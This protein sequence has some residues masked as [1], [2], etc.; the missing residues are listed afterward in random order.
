[1]QDDPLRSSRTKMR[2]ERATAATLFLLAMS[3]TACYPATE[4]QTPTT[5]GA[6]E[7][8]GAVG[9]RVQLAPAM[10]SK[11]I[12]LPMPELALRLG[13]AEGWDIGARAVNLLGLTG[14]ELGIKHQLI[15]GDV[16]VAVAPAL[17][18][19]ADW[20]G[21]RNETLP[22]V[23][24]TRLP[25]FIKL[26]S[27]GPVTPWLAPT[28]HAGHL[29][30]DVVVDGP[31]LAAGLTAGMKLRIFKGF[32]I[33]PQLGLLM[34][35]HAPPSHPHE[36]DAETPPFQLGSRRMRVEFALALFSQSG[37]S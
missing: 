8:Q 7:F 12:P 24:A 26:P 2:Y 23:A 9:T 13:V 3:L 22:V 16:A 1:M 35:L 34:P 32:S 19:T 25:V 27:A 10:R 20:E 37:E 11:P 17:I 30:G 21:T 33:Q 36:P 14:L 29:M 15:D 5:L 31:F 4:L 28:M 6:G 18:A